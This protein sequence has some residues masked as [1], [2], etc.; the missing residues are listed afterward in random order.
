M[1]SCCIGFPWATA[2]N[3]DDIVPKEIDRHGVKRLAASGAQIVDVMGSSEYE[4]SHL[5]GAIHIPLA[6]IPNRALEL[7]DPNR[8]V[9]VYCYDSL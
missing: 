3:G 2:G 5:P 4:Q 1:R 8:P 9:V 7:L 6:K